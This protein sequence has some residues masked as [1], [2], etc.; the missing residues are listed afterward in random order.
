MRDMWLDLSGEQHIQ[1]MMATIH[2]VV[3][4]QENVATVS[5]VNNMEEQRVLEEL[6]ETSKPKRPEGFEDYHYLLITPFRYPPLKNGSRFGRSFEPSLFYGS[7]NVSTAL[8][9][10][11]YYQFVFMSGMAQPFNEARQI[12]Y[13]SFKVSIKTK[14]G[15]FLDR[16]PFSQYESLITSK[17]TY[18]NTQNLGASMR[19]A[20]VESFQYLSA[21]APKRGR[22]L[23]LFTPKAFQSKKPISNERWVCKATNEEVGFLSTDNETRVSF[24]K[25][26]F[27]TGEIIPAPSC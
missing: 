18:V 9:E 14:Q 10:T 3:E 21:R 26:C 17:V 2:R 11:A 23:A 5:L 1:P 13:S 16:A 20:N 15:I 19:E 7:L 4:D 12:L 22:N 25:Q 8:S 24:D 6:L 27:L